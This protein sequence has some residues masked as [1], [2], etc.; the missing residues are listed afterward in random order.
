E[1]LA[2]PV[3]L[4]GPDAAAHALLGLLA[5][6]V[7]ETDERERRQATL[8]VR[9]RLDPARFEADEGKRDPACKHASTLARALQGVCDDRAPKSVHARDEDVLEELAGAQARAAVDVAA[10][11]FLEVQPCALEDLRIQLAAVV[12]DDEHGRARSQ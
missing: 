2:R 12:Y 10:Q 11:P 9:L 3:Q 7:D 5:R 4:G 6:P 8:G 1:H